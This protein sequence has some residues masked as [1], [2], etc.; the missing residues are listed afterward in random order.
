MQNVECRM[1]KGVGKVEGGG[2]SA[3]S[4]FTVLGSG[5]TAD[6][7]RAARAFSLIEL[8]V[9]IAVIVVLAAMTFPAMQGVKATQARKRAQAELGMIETAIEAYHT[10]LGY[11][12]P[13]NPLSPNTNWCVNQLYYELIG[14][15]LTGVQYQTLDGSASVPANVPGFKATFG[16][17]TKL[18]GFMNSSKPGAGDDTPNAVRFLTGLK[19]AQYLAVS[20]TGVGTWTALGVSMSGSPDYPGASSGDIIPYGYNSSSPV[21]NP[22]SFDLW[23]D[24]I[25]NGKTNRISN[26]STKP[27]IVYYPSIVTAYY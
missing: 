2:R 15:T 18:T 9:V 17:N 10:K 16:G 5:M 12:P 21:H 24:I 19:P 27:T 26:W 7:V 13:D 20:V 6:A 1:Q 22:K 25:V 3:A 4:R 23:V 11:Y 8:L 14:T